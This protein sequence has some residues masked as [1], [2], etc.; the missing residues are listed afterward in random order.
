MVTF[1]TPHE[2]VSK[3]PFCFDG[4]LCGVINF[5]ARH[6]VYLDIVQRNFGPAGYF[7]DQYHVYNFRKYSHFLADLNS[8][9][10]HTYELDQELH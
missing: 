5:F 8:E 2:G 1:G 3:V 7:R 4:I 6:L 10:T 9:S